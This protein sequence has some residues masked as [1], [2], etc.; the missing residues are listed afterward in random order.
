M[1]VQPSLVAPVMEQVVSLGGSY[2][3]GMRH[4]ETCIENTTF[5]FKTVQFYWSILFYYKFT[6]A[7]FEWNLFFRAS[8]FTLMMF[9]EKNLGV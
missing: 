9:T 2:F 7:H 1:D 8:S 3:I 4:Y 6:F 5:K